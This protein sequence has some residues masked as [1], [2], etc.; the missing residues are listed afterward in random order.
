MLWSEELHNHVIP[1]TTPQTAIVTAGL[2]FDTDAEYVV[3]GVI[4]SNGTTRRDK[5]KCH[6]SACA[7]ATFGRLADLKRHNASR[8]EQ[9]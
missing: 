5:Y 3:V 1:V 6:T 9:S 7:G 8:H 4:L 2:K